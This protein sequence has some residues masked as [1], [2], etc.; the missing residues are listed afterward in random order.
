MDPFLHR[1]MHFEVN[2][3]AELGEG[4]ETPAAE[5]APDPEPAAEAAPA[6][7]FSSPEFQEAVRQHAGPAAQQQLA[8]LIA[9]LPGEEEP[10]QFLDPLGMEPEQFTGGLQDMFGKML[11]ER[12]APLM[13][14]VERQQAQDAQGFVNEQIESLPQIAAVSELLPAPKEGE[15]DT[16]SQS[17]S[18]LI[19]LVSMGFL[20]QAE[21]AY[22]AGE[23][24]VTAALRAGAHHVEQS[25]K[26]AYDAGRA[27]LTADQE[28]V[29]SAGEPV[30]GAAA[31]ELPAEA[32][33]VFEAA[34]RFYDRS[35]HA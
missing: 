27:S 31:A 6:L 28:R 14:T 25:M 26:Q 4:E 3:D 18:D 1:F 13:Q 19:E 35:Q 8:D 10:Q 9:N 30:N 12:L 22:G 5:A 2:P 29:A 23:Q 24:A 33:D 11:D 16:R 34:N 20:P 21:A 15:E 7:D 32:S 17:A